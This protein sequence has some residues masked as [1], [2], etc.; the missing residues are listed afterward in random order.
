MFNLFAMASGTVSDWPG[1]SE[2]VSTRSVE[3]ERLEVAR[4]AA[5]ER[6]SSLAHRGSGGGSG[7]KFPS[8]GGA[9]Q[10]ARIAARLALCGLL[11]VA[12]GAAAQQRSANPATKPPRQKSSPTAHAPAHPKAEA[13]KPAAPD[14]LDKHVEAARTYQLAEDYTS[15]ASEYRKVIA[16][17]LQRLGNLSVSEGKYAEAVR[18]LQD[19]VQSDPASD[20]I[21][22]DLAVAHLYAGDFDKAEATLEPVL[23]RQ[24]EDFRALNLLGRVYFLQGKYEPAAN[25]LHEAMTVRDDPDVLYTMALAHLAAG[26]LPNATALFDDLRATVP[27]TPELHMLLGQAYQATKHLDEADR[28]FRKAQALDPKA[29]RSNFLLGIDDL[30]RATPDGYAAARAHFAAETVNSP[31]DYS[32][33]YLLGVVQL[34]QNLLPEAESSLLTASKLDAGNPDPWFYLARIYSDLGNSDKAIAALKKTIALTSDPNRNEGQLA[35]AHYMLGQALLKLGNREQGTA[36]VAQSQQL[37]T[38]YPQKMSG[39]GAPGTLEQLSMQMADFAQQQLQSML[40]QRPPVSVSDK[41]R[42]AFVARLADL[43]GN[44]YH[45]L[46]VIDARAGRFADA[47]TEFAQAS[48]W[49]PNIPALDRNWAVAAFRAEKYADAITPLKRQLDHSPDDITSREMLGVSYYMVDDYPHS[50][51]VFKPV[52]DRLPDNAGILLAAGTSLVRSG[53]T[54]DAKKLFNRLLQRDENVPELHLMLGQAHAEAKEYPDAVS[55]FSRALE[56]N[57]RLADAHFNL[58]M[59]DF[60]QGK[61]DDAAQQFRQELSLNPGS[62]PAQYQLAYVLLQQHQA[63][64]AIGLL[65]KVVAQQPKYADA[66]Y[67]LG[68]GL[69]EQSKVPEATQELETAVKIQPTDYAYYQLSIAYRRSGRDADA[70]HAM[71]MYAKLKPKPPNRPNGIPQ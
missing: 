43:L 37:Q 8:A 18:L 63:D 36:E 26:K 45:N 1:F 14:P 17:C 4:L 59:V 34:G 7:T 71:D 33:H 57:P 32:S 23:K 27:D 10:F 50:A 19:A 49:Q 11:S 16:I 35:R 60:R 70:Q 5:A 3:C 9:A 66:H 55:E 41:E 30:L 6:R 22:E 15:A 25:E 2:R 69:L 53:D 13:T 65:Q 62:V 51:Q 46:G 64:E 44:S 39:M 40:L 61:I 29:P 12:C 52:L 31:K 20:D 54:D 67:Q 47:S 38:K 24:P 42:T 58:G 21:A 56:L 68:K 48:Q 28:E